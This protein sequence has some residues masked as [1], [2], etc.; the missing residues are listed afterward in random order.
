[1]AWE[2]RL[3]AGDPDPDFDIHQFLFGKHED[4]DE[5][6]QQVSVRPDKADDE[7]AE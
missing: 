6:E 3:L 1:M 4:V 2:G 7:E 5:A